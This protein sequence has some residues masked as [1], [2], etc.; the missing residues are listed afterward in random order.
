MSDTEPNG[1]KLLSLR[2]ASQTQRWGVSP[3]QEAFFYWFSSAVCGFLC[4]YLGM[5]FARVIK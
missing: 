3:V 4:L 5:V 2:L 1:S